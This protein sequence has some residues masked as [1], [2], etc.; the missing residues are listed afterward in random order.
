[1]DA[2]EKPGG[3]TVRGT[4]TPLVRCESAART[5]G[6]GP[7]AVVAVHGLN[8]VIPP[9]ARIAVVGP[10]GSGKSTLL[11]L[12]AGLDSPTAGRVSHP[13]LGKGDSEGLARYIG[14]IFQGP[15]LLPPLTA[16][17]NVALPLRIDGVREG[18]ADVRAAAALESLGLEVLAG[19]LPDELSAGQAQRVAVARVLARRPRLVLADEPTGQLDRETGRQVLTV[20]LGAAEE[21]GAA[22]LVTTHDPRVAR[23]LGVRW[24]MA[25]GRLIQPD[26]SAGTSGS[27]APPG[28]PRGGERQ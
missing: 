14:V 16:A 13:G 17:E 22:V 27:T 12:M 19:R 15:S 7:G 26:E 9:G 10:S 3:T 23:E 11:H 2:R 8:C 28:Q 25:D 4:G 24:Y 21:L 20:L 18:E 6:S 5:Y 1:M